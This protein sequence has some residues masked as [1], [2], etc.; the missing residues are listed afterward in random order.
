MVC[1]YLAKLIDINPIVECGL[2][3]EKVISD[4]S[5]VALGA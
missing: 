4:F 2:L 5:L 1:L 3:P